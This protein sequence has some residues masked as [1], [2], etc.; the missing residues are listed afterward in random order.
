MPAGLLAFYEKSFEKYDNTNMIWKDK[1][2][3][4]ATFSPYVFALGAGIRFD[5][6]DW[7][8]LK[9]FVQP[10]SVEL[11]GLEYFSAGMRAE[12]KI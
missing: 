6:T 12:F 4:L 11:T 3:E 5:I 10:P 7:L 2:S 9:V 8:R 1:T